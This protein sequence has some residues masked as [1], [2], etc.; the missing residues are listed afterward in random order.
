MRHAALMHAQN[1]ADAFGLGRASSLSAP[2]ARGELGE[3]RRLDTDRGTFAVKREFERWSV[4][5]AETSTAY[6]RVCWEAGIP[7]PEPLR[8]TTGGF[9]APVG[10]EQVRAYA[11]A[12]LADPD[13][14]L[15]PAAV[16]TLVARLHQVRYPWPTH[17]VD[18]WFEAPIGREVWNAVLKAS[19]AAGAPH[20]DRLLALVPALLE[21]EE[22]LTP[23]RPV[24]T[25]HLDL[26]AD[27]L[28]SSGGRPC[29]I[30]FDNAGPGDPSRE[31]AMV[32][33][34]FGRGDALRQRTLYD[35]YLAADGP[36]RIRNRADLGLAVAQLHHIGHRHLTM[37]VAAREAEARARSLAGIDEFLGEPLLLPDVDALLE[38][39]R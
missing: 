13:L 14:T 16:G 38:A 27:N 35:A 6:H 2:V 8:A 30:D 5:E 18:A 32:A 22:I 24:Q 29:A 34:E 10:G 33:F 15:D 4:D 1:V 31:I 26:W 12:E 39:L 28:R 23:M 37:W 25:C 3:I 7:T 21:I 19:R 9:T 36:G 11:W 20:A 17:E